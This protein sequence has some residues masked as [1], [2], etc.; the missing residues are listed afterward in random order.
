V[1]AR[2]QQPWLSPPRRRAIRDGL[3]VAGAIFNAVVI[4]GWGSRNGLGSDLHP[5][6]DARSWWLIDLSDLYGRAEIS[7]VASGAFRLS[8]AVAWLMYPLTWLSWPAF[9]A[10][11]L[12]LS[13][14]A[15]TILGRRW[16]PILIVAFPPILLEGLNGNIHLFMALAIWAGL[17]W[18]AAWAFILLTKVTPGVGLVWFVA[19]R[20]WRNLA[21][22]IGATAAIIAVG[23]L[24]APSLWV[25][26]LRF[27]VRA[28]E[29]P[30]V[31]TPLP[32]LPLRLAISIVVIW[33]AARTDRAWIVPIGC[34]IAMPTLWLQSTALL[35]ACFPLWWERARWMRQ[36]AKPQF[37]PQAIPAAAES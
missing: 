20:E 28:A 30:T 19:R 14:V 7:L 8:P 34:M 5:W 3:L 2:S 9:I 29:L 10:V 17:R 4:F 26:W 37:A 31:P 23:V 36:P 24:L 21:I 11:Y 6:E 25:E 16:T 15:V 33:Y 35:T 22:A 32:G 18:P 1:T 27:L 13:V 12:A